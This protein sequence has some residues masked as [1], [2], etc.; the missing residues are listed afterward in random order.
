MAFGFNPAGNGFPSQAPEG[1]PNFILFQDSGTDLGD[2]DADTVN[3]R[4]GLRA[5]RGAG[6]SSG[7][8]TVDANAFIWT[9]VSIDYTLTEADVS[10]GVKS[11]SEDTSLV[12]TVPG[13]TE[14]GI[15]DTDGIDG[16]SLLIEQHGAAVVSVVGQSGVTVNVRSGLTAQTAGQYA[17]LSLIRVGAN[18]WVLCGD[19][20]TA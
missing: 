11:V 8:V 4:R 10:N 13:D 19:L 5:T 9:E 1:F 7:V 12:I 20:E 6:E 18:E 2:A 16:A 3:F 15:E 14:L 17:V